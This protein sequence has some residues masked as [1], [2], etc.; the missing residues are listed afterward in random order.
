LFWTSEDLV[1]ALA[2]PEPEPAP[3]PRQ[4][5]AR[6]I[7]AGLPPGTNR[8]TKATTLRDRLGIGLMEAIRLVAELG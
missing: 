2:E 6:E 8:L 5:Q 4:V 3:E 7:L 1:N